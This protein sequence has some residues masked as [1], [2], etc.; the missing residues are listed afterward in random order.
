[1][2]L[3]FLSDL[4]S[5]ELATEPSKKV[6]LATNP[7]KHNQRKATTN[8]SHMRLLCCTSV[9]SQTP[10]SL[11]HCLHAS[12]LGLPGRLKDALCHRQ[13]LRIEGERERHPAD[14]AM[15]NAD[16]VHNAPQAALMSWIYNH[17]YHHRSQWCLHKMWHPFQV[18]SEL[19]RRDGMST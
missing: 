12:I 15:G 18:R 13:C 1:M 8:S 11:L 2:T 7:G 10:C 3:V 17:F 19:L 14:R 6:M 16:L 5:L 4:A 9:P